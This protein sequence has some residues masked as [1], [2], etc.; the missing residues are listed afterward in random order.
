[1]YVDKFTGR[2]VTAYFDDLRLDCPGL[3]EKAFK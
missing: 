2:P 3:S 1:M